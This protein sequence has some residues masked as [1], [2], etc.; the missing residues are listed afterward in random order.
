MSS[1][2]FVVVVAVPNSTELRLC[3]DRFLMWCQPD[4]SNCDA[5]QHITRGGWR[6]SRTQ[7]GSVKSESTKKAALTKKI[8]GYQSKFRTAIVA[9][10]YDT[11][12]K[13]FLRRSTTFYEPLRGSASQG[14]LDMTYDVICDARGSKIKRNGASMYYKFSLA[15][16]N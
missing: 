16:L 6:H 4:L 5:A 11:P 7:R 12:C 8:P 10:F 1:Q 15:P 2:F 13:R 14:T 9:K 3:S